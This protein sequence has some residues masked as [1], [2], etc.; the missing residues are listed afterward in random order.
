MAR[1]HRYETRPSHYRGALATPPGGGGAACFAPSTS[2]WSD[3][4]EA[5]NELGVRHAPA[6]RHAGL[7]RPAGA[8]PNEVGRKSNLLALMQCREPRVER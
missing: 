8:V 1:R 2:L 6:H 4:R 5:G 7:S 3:A